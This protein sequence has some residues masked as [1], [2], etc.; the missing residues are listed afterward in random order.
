MDEIWGCDTDDMTTL[1][2]RFIEA[3]SRVRRLIELLSSASM[4]VTWTGPDADTHRESTEAVLAELDALGT[5]VETRGQGL[6]D[7]AAQQEEASGP[8]SGTGHAPAL[9]APGLRAEL[10][11]WHPAAG[12]D[13]HRSSPDSPGGVSG[14]PP[15][16]RPFVEK[17]RRL[18]DGI[19]PED[20]GLGPWIGGPM[21]P[22]IGGRD[23]QRVDTGGLVERLRESSDERVRIPLPGGGEY[24][25]DPD[26]LRLAEQRRRAAVGSIPVASRVQQAVSMH[27]L[28][29]EELDAMEAGARASGIPLATAAVGAARL[30]HELSGAVLGDRSLVGQALSSIDEEIANYQ[31]TGQEVSDAIGERDPGAVFGALERGGYRHLGVIADRVTLTSLPGTLDAAGGAAGAVGDMV[32][33]ISGEAADV[34]HETERR[35]DGHADDAEALLDRVTDTERLYETRRRHLPLPWE[36]GV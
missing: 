10:P 15:A 11:D 2:D 30:P 16:L 28:R 17:G 4:S 24:E 7:E 27:E 31:Q 32:E 18:V 20:E 23:P 9:S 8:E 25:L 29:D 21:G 19:S 36:D 26:Q 34:L 35:L 6:D 3:A 5:A 1:A 22:T 12:R 33:P 13:D 14:I